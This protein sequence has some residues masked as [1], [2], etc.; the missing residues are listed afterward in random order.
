LLEKHPEIVNDPLVKDNK[1]TALMR[2]AF[3]GNLELLNLLI[4]FNADPNAVTPKGETALSIAV[5][6][7]R[8]EIA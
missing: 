5:K 4:S 2:I 7:D 3:N 8:L 1:Q 6:R